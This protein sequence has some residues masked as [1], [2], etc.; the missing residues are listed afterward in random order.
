MA[1]SAP[2]RTGERHV[3]RAVQREVQHGERSVELQR[4]GERHV[5]KERGQRLL[6]RQE[7]RV[8]VQMQ[9]PERGAGVSG[10]KRTVGQQ[11]RDADEAAP[12]RGSRVGL[13]RT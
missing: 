2:S 10:S 1:R 7:G 8:D 11:G 9:A 4:A 12:V 13:R 6:A 3:R 5:E